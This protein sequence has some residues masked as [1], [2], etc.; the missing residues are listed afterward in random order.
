MLNA[1]PDGVLVVRDDR[2]V[3]SNER[4]GSLLENTDLDGLD[5]V[6]VDRVL[7]AVDSESLDAIVDPIA[8]GRQEFGG[9]EMEL[10]VPG[11]GR[12]AAEVSIA[13]AN[14]QG[15][16]A[17]VY[18]VADVS[19]QKTVERELAIKS[20]A[21]D[22]APVG[23][24]LADAEADD[25]PLVYANE[26]FTDMTG[27]SEAEILG[28]NCRF[29]QGE[30]TS[31]EPV[32]AIR[33][34]IEAA[35]P[36]TVELLNYRK[37]GSEFWNRLTVAP[38]RDDDG[39][40]THYVG[41]QENVT[42]WV[43]AQQD[44][45]RFKEAVEAAGQAIFTTDMDGRITY[46]NPA[47]EA[48]TGHDPDE[49]VG[50]NSRVLRSGHHDDAYYDRLWETVRRGETWTEEIIDRHADGGEYHAIQ[51]VSPISDDDGD[52]EEFVA[53]QTDITARKEHERHLAT[54]DRVLRHD[55]RNRLNVV[56]GHVEAIREAAT[57]DP[58]AD[59]AERALAAVNDL[60]RMADHSREINRMLL[61][62]PRPMTVEIIPAVRTGLDDFRE[63]HPDATIAFSTSC[64]D[65]LEV[66]ATENVAEA[67]TRTVEYLLGHAD[68]EHLR[69]EVTLFETD[70]GVRI[71]VGDDAD[72]IPEIEQDV[73]LKTDDIGSLNHGTGLD[74]WFVYWVV[75]RSNG[76]LSFE[77]VDETGNVVTIDLLT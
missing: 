1:I 29:L 10:L 52:I 62:Q 32:R 40:V 67:V 55:L 37:D 77:E 76:S 25:V 46:A 12:V 15:A 7:R 66:I 18:V 13:R 21:M 64:P 34:A 63:K 53:I 69:I 4:A 30:E 68:D 38:I 8:D 61:D 36:V 43:S 33:E 22:D 14:W 72:P 45:R 17:I 65:D 6:R 31:A 50:E 59:H 60:L 42:E 20:R 57:S 19:G 58:A 75:H 70:D 41:F 49:V 48:V 16:P 9:A 11:R 47:F 3:F 2:I 74:L 71:R 56:V 27:Y 44:L 5:D 23:I 28:R 51:T 39:D 73:L 35:E 26:R 24:V 54:L